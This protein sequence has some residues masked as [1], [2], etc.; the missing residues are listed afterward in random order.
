MARLQAAETAKTASATSVATS[1]PSS[2]TSSASSSTG[3]GSG[4]VTQPKSEPAPSTPTKPATPAKPQ[5]GYDVVVLFGVIPPETPAESAQLTPYE[6]IKLFTALPSAQLPLIA[7]RGVTA[8]GK[9]AT[10]TLVGEVILH[11]GA[12]CLPSASQCQAIGLK[13]GQTEQL[14][15]LTPGGQAITYELR[16]VSISSKSASA[17]SVKDLLGDSSKAGREL[18]SREGLMTLPGLRYSS[19]AGV[20]VLA[21]HPAFTA[22]SSSHH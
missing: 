22:H 9:S 18:L 1:P 19:Q 15:Y 3:S 13:A 10:F 17:A 14:E 11:G 16:I 21:G 4:S 2:S 5:P 7:Y 20:L 12:V 6:N 8:K